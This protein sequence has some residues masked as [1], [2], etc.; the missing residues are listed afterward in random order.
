MGPARA[1]VATATSIKTRT[2]MRAYLV[3]ELPGWDQWL[4]VMAATVNWTAWDETVLRSQ[5]ELLDDLARFLE[6]WVSSVGPA[7]HGLFLPFAQR[8][9]PFSPEKDYPAAEPFA[10][11]QEDLMSRGQGL[12]S[13]LLRQKAMPSR[14]LLG[15]A[16]AVGLVGHERHRGRAPD[17]RL[18]D[19][20][21]LVVRD[22]LPFVRRTGPVVP[23]PD[24]TDP[25]FNTAK[26]R[27]A[28]V[29]IE[30][31]AVVAKF[32]SLPHRSDPE[33]EGGIDAEQAM[34]T[35]KQIRAVRARL[36]ARARRGT[37]S[38]KRR[39]TRAGRG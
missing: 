33:F 35:S 1:V 36:R 5:R 32:L 13:V 39:A 22:L 28:P 24:Y 37:P 10:N 26:A 29:P 21:E 14:F 31:V 34:F 6:E 17:S 7:A 4:I 30:L 9:G 25:G 23:P 2:D 12:V 20:L 3:S 16:G 27:K 18:D 38:V 15:L 11:W 8:R 19:A